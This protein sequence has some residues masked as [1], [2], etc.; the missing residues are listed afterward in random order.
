MISGTPFLVAEPG[1]EALTIEAALRGSR[2][3]LLT[4][5]ELDDLKAQCEEGSAL[6]VLCAVGVLVL[7]LEAAAEGLELFVKLAVASER[8]AFARH[9]QSVRAI[10][11]DLGATTIAF[12]TRR[13]GWARVLG[14]QWEPR[15][16]FEFVRYVD[17]RR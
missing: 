11:R 8:G 5:A 6:C 13:P 2:H 15:G 4:P 12:Q 1:T 3:Q 14:P 10:A 17:G 16:A 9:E 7:S